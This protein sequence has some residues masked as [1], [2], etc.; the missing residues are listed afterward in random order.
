ME[1]FIINILLVCLFVC[2]AAAKEEFKVTR[3]VSLLYC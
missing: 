2:L 3:T 1:K